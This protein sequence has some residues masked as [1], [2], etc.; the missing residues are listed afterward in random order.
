MVV[1]PRSA[2]GKARWLVDTSVLARID[3]PEI[4]EVMLPRIQA[5]LVG[6]SIMTELEA[7][8]AAR[9][10]SGY[11]SVRAD[12]LDHLVPVLVPNRTELRAR[13]VQARL[14]E[15]GEHRSVS[16]PEMLL[17]AIAESG[18]LTLLHYRASFDVVAAITGQ[19]TEWVVPRGS[20]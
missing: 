15:R 2:V 20:A 5:G 7:G 4:A 9:S 18:G 8:F 16:V 12:L 10:M 19:P 11:G 17:A 13:E 6:V 3:H 14:V 1:S